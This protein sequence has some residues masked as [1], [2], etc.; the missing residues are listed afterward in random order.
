MKIGNYTI[1]KP[2][3]FCAS[4]NLGISDK[5]T[6]ISYK[7]K[8]HVAVYCKD[9]RAYGPRV[10]SDRREKYPHVAGEEAIKKAIQLWDCRGN[11]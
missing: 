1:S 8:R 5:T 7:K 9:C 2:C 10:I 6:T 4:K 11:K 3:R